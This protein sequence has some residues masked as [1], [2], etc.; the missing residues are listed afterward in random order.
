VAAARLTLICLSAA[1]AVLAAA[2]YL[3]LS[4]SLKQPSSAAAGVGMR[5][6]SDGAAR[7]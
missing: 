5:V 6:H 3:Q 7:P 2:A 1:A 4:Q